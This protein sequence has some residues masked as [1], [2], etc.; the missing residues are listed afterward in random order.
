M[1]VVLCTVARASVAQQSPIRPLPPSVDA[2]PKWSRVLHMPDGRTFV[3]DGGFT[4][5]A[6]IAKPSTMPATVLPDETGARFSRIF[7]APFDREI[8]MSELRPGSLQNTFVTP[9]N[10]VLNGNYVKFLGRT[11]PP[12]RVRLRVKGQFDPVVIVVD[13]QPI[14]VLMP[15]RH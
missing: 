14:G 3:T 8:R 9:G 4:I 13:K 15:V 11:V 10:I 1:A 2:P 5:D 7:S 12:D 6:A